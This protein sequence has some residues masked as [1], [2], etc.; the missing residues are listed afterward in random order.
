MDKTGIFNK[1]LDYIKNE[2]YRESAKNLLEKVPDYFFEIP[3][4][5]T[6]KYHPDFATGEGGL[7]RHTKVALRIALEI[8]SLEYM[9]EVFT[10]REKDLLLVAIM[11]HDTQKLG[12]PMEKYTRFDHPLLAANFIKENK[13]V[14]SFNNDDIIFIEKAIS[15]HMGQW[16]TSD[17]SNIT[18]PKP[19]NKYEFFVHQ[20]DYLAS[21]KFINVEFD[22]NEIV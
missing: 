14:T 16:N 7:V 20:C 13:N 12:D 15:A 10:D 17:Y 2:K 6:G 5:S 11:F 22:N 9:S 21:R 1:E 8:L 19:N 3:A 4:S 18:L